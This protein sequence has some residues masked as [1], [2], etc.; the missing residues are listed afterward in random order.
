MQSLYE[1]T[2]Y[3]FSL[4]AIQT[5]V[6]ALAMLYLGIYALIRGQGTP[7]A[8]VFFVITLCMGI[9]IFA[10]SWMYASLDYRLAMWWAKVGHVGIAFIPAAVHH[11]SALMMQNQ[12]K[13][14]KRILILWLAGA[15]FAAIN[16]VTDVQFGS[17]YSYSW[18]VFPHSGLSSVPFLL[19]FFGVMVIALRNYLKGFRAPGSSHAQRMRARI[20]LIGFGVGS[21]ALFDFVP[22]YGIGMYPFGYIPMFFFC[23]IAAYSISRYR[24][25]EITPALAA[26]EIIDTMNDALIVLDP[27][28]VVRLVNQATCSL[29][30]YRGRDLIG[31]RLQDSMHRSVVFA[32]QLE[33]TI[34]SGTVLNQ[35]VDYQ[36]EGGM[37][38]HTLSL[39]TS[40]VHSPEGEALATVCV[41]RASPTAIAS[42]GSGN[43][44][45]PS[46]RR[47]TGNCRRST[48]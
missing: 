21:L 23:I 40:T 3:A 42:S 24:F 39:S 22:A 11:F 48:G 16:N 2:L 30:G 15:V 13:T 31:K 29:F 25:K 1:N 18:G 46:C 12:E 20:L 28:G 41:V 34:R 37:H 44:S 5:L 35:D 45:S 7:V 17:L 8:V 33:S 9:W 10:F 38:H 36:P 27:D 32:A 4:L 6:V 26:G 43:G 14:R 19:Y 47:Q